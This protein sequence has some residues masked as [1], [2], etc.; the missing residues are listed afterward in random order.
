MGLSEASSLKKKKEKKIGLM[1][2]DGS[3]RNL[4]PSTIGPVA[5]APRHLAQVGR[6]TGH[7]TR[8]TSRIR[9]S[10]ITL[11]EGVDGE[12]LGDAFT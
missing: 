7:A 11:S 8:Y 4:P 3:F 1:V 12:R 2:Y 9:L 5:A 10:F 6:S